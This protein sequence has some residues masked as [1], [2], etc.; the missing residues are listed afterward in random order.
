[1]LH[2]HMHCMLFIDVLPIHPPRVL[3]QVFRQ[4]FPNVVDKGGN[5]R[6]NTIIDLG[7]CHGLVIFEC[8]H[9]PTVIDPRQIRL[10]GTCASFRKII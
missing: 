9:A 2:M 10:E 6:T 7:I 4:R 8:V 1:M 5:P 3:E